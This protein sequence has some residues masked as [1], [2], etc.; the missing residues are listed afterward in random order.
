MV[1]Q[2]LPMNVWLDRCGRRITELDQ[3]IADDEARSI[4]RDMH[5]FER[6]RAMEPEAAAE[7]VAAQL[8]SAGAARFERRHVSRG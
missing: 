6:T 4:A 8:A 5:H 2:T 3:E 7:F 1:L